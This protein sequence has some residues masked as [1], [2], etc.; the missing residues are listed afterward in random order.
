MTKPDIKEFA[1]IKT[2]NSIKAK[3]ISTLFGLILSLIILSHCNSAYSQQLIISNKT[4]SYPFVVTQNSN[5]NPHVFNIVKRLKQFDSNN[6]LSISF[7]IELN[8]KITKEFGNNYIVISELSKKEC[9]SG[10]LYRDFDI[11]SEFFP[12]AVQFTFNI[13]QNN[14][15]LQIS[16]EA[17]L[18]LQKNIEQVY[19]WTDTT[20][21]SI[22]EINP[23]LISL[24]YNQQW[25]SEMNRKLNLI[26]LYYQSDSLLI[27]WDSIVNSIKLD[28]IELLPI[29]DFV[30]DE[31]EKSL[32]S[33]NNS[34]IL[35][36]VNPNRLNYQEFKDRITNLNIKVGQ[37]RLLLT[38]YLHWID[39]RFIEKARLDLK[40]SNPIGAI[41]N[42]SKALEYN[43]LSIQALSELG[44]IMLDQNNLSE[45]SNLVK[46]IFSSTWPQGKTLD[47]CR[48]LATDL[49]SAIV[50]KGNLLLK[51][52]EFHRAIQAFS[53]ANIFCDSIRENICTNE[54]YQG[55]V[56]SK[57]GILRSYFNVINKALNRDLLH[58]AENYA[59]EAKKYQMANQKEI[60]DDSEIQLIVDQI[61][62]KYVSLAMQNI[63]KGKFET[64]IN[65]LHNA[66]SLGHTFR[67]NF[68]LKYLDDSRK[69]AFN[70]AF[71]VSLSESQ[72]ALNNSNIY[73]A[74]S[75]HHDAMNFYVQHPEWITDTTSA[76][77]IFLNIRKA[78]LKQKVAFGNNLYIN[79]AFSDA[80]NMLQEAKSIETY[81]KFQS[82]TLLDSLL[83]AISKPIAFERLNNVSMKIWRNELLEAKAIIDDVD[84]L[85]HKSN[86]LND[87][88]LIELF[89]STKRKYQFQ[90]CDFAQSQISQFENLYSKSILNQSFSIAL[91]AI[92]SIQII[93]KSF[94]RCIVNPKNYD[95]DYKI[96]IPAAKYERLIQDC[97]IEFRLKNTRKALNIFFIADSLYQKHALKE[98]GVFQKTLSTFFYQTPDFD[99]IIEC[100]NWL[101][102][103]PHTDQIIPLLSILER[104]GCPSVKAKNIQK[105]LALKLRFSDK[106]EYPTMKS[107]ELINRYPVKNNW[108]YIFKRTYLKNPITAFFN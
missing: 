59:Y 8:I 51:E 50:S 103:S 10:A 68:S 21:N 86:L 45:S 65:Q 22:F 39:Y 16:H 94:S 53:I 28:Q 83:L 104:N 108:Y 54:H 56:K 33:F 46:T 18:K 77:S 1:I 24:N 72:F 79:G 96:I 62:T 78:D 91:T 49:Y 3:P 40:M 106:T 84:S 52:E 6:D 73:L 66:D 7:T 89:N 82:D 25:E 85:I 100:C 58:I 97:D 36:I 34:N 81:Y 67:D 95:S 14:K 105:N 80:L 17:S 69:K 61:V 71:S 19:T 5:L 13:V 63:D 43:P 27:A 87:V 99:L 98:A 23:N 42:Y 76:Y 101:L 12:S 48:K 88:E 32:E 30:L 107:S 41:Y 92:D 20:S 60:P 35:S 64:A 90:E 47:E 55:I 15:A 102:E 44:R 74:D 70:G 11:C 9:P 37:K 4:Y 29:N 26:D 38:E 93:Q 57:Y 31:V 2:N 75:K